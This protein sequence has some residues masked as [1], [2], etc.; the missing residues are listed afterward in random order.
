MVKVKYSTLQS[1][2]LKKVE[3]TMKEIESKDIYQRFFKDKRLIHNKKAKRA[4]S[5]LLA[6]NFWQNDYKK[7]GK[8]LKRRRQVSPLERSRTKY[9]DNFKKTIFERHSKLSIKEINDIGNIENVYIRQK[10]R[11][12]MDYQGIQLEN[13][14]HIKSIKEVVD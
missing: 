10:T 11:N 2:M 14:K 1:M 3:N 9:L 13:F 8:M 7:R 4:I 5:K 6:V 12:A